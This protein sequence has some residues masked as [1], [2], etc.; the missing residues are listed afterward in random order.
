MF[1]TA[2]AVER[3]EQRGNEAPAEAASGCSRAPPSGCPQVF[4]RSAGRKIRWKH[5]DAVC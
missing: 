2:R 1:F 3:V 4:A 5:Q